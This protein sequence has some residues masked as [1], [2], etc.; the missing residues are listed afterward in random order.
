MTWICL[1][2][3][4]RP[5]HKHWINSNNICRMR[6]NIF[7]KNICV[8]ISFDVDYTGITNEVTMKEV[9]VNHTLEEIMAMVDKSALLAQLLSDPT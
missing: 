3:A 9:Q 4:T 8:V 7:D 6:S 2:D 5:N 1:N